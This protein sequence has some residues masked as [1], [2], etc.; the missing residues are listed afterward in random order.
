MKTTDSATPTLGSTWRYKSTLKKEDLAKYNAL[1]ATAESAE[2]VRSI[3][4]Q[5]YRSRLRKLSSAMREHWLDTR[6]SHLLQRPLDERD[7]LLFERWVVDGSWR[8]RAIV[9]EAGEVV[10]ERF[11]LGSHSRPY[12][13]LRRADGTEDKLSITTPLPLIQKRVAAF[14]QSQ[15]RLTLDEVPRGRKPGSRGIGI[16]PTL[17]DALAYLFEFRGKSKSDLLK[18]CDRQTTSEDYRWLNRRLTIGRLKFRS[19]RRLKEVWDLMGLDY[20]EGYVKYILASST[21]HSP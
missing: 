17:P 7:E 12:L 9:N 20:I 1:V 10:G 14:V 5:R 15:R 6:V 19:V 2:G 16:E 11:R 4:R 13:L 21:T 18:L 3:L 8:V